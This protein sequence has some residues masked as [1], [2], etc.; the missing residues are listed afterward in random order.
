VGLPQRQERA[1]LPAEA[2]GCARSTAAEAIKVLEDA[3][4]LSW[5][6]LIKRVRVRCPDLFGAGVRMVLQRTSNTLRHFSFNSN[7]CSLTNTSLYSHLFTTITIMVA[8][9]NGYLL[10]P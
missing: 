2:A 3:G 4:V 5:V 8:R 9:P 1:L 6:Q 10:V 7:G